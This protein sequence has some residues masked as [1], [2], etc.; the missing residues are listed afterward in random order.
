MRY[1][2]VSFF[3]QKPYFFC[4][5][6]FIYKDTSAMKLSSFAPSVA[7][8]VVTASAPRATASSAPSP[9]SQARSGKLA[10][11]NQVGV[12][13]QILWEN[14]LSVFQDIRLA[15]TALL[16]ALSPKDQ[17]RLQR[18]IAELKT[19]KNKVTPGEINAIFQEAIQRLQVSRNQILALYPGSK[20]VEL[21]ALP[22]RPG[23]KRR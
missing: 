16:K 15:R 5:Y 8:S 4:V 6:K 21:Q 22:V 2:V 9:A 17:Q 23:T 10:V 12:S 20:R 19:K 13:Q 1:C 7:P 14:L 18:R 3:L 11:G